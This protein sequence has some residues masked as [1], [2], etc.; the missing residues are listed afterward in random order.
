MKF[1]IPRD[2]LEQGLFTA[3]QHKLFVEVL[4]GTRK[5]TRLNPE[6][7]E[8]YQKEF[9]DNRAEQCDSWFMDTVLNMIEDHCQDVGVV[10]CMFA[11]TFDRDQ[12]PKFVRDVQEAVFNHMEKEKLYERRFL[13]SFF[14]IGG[15]W[16]WYVI[17]HY[18]KVCYT[19]DSFNQLAGLEKA[20]EEIHP[21][22]LLA[23][24]LR[25][26]RDAWK[27]LT[28][29][30]IAAFITRAVTCPEQLAYDSVSCGQLACASMITFLMRIH[31]DAQAIHRFA[32]PITGFDGRTAYFIKQRLV[33]SMAY[34][35]FK[36][37]LRSVSFEPAT[38]VEVTPQ[39]VAQ[40]S[41]TICLKMQVQET[42]DPVS[43][44]SMALERFCMENADVY[45]VPKPAPASIP[46]FLDPKS[47]LLSIC[48][49]Y[50]NKKSDTIRTKVFVG[51]QLN[52]VWIFRSYEELLVASV[53]VH[54]NVNKKGCDKSTVQ[55][56]QALTQNV[57][58]YTALVWNQQYNAIM[59]ATVWRT[60]LQSTQYNKDR[61]KVPKAKRVLI[62]S[63]GIWKV[64]QYGF[65]TYIKSR[66]PMEPG[67][68][69]FIEVQN[70]KGRKSKSNSKKIQTKMEQRRLTASP[71]GRPIRSKTWITIVKE[72]LSMTHC[73]QTAKAIFAYVKE[74]QPCY[75]P[76]LSKIRQA[77]T[78]GEQ[79]AAKRAAEF[80]N[81]EVVQGKTNQSFGGL[82]EN[83]RYH[84]ILPTNETKDE[85][86]EKCIVW[87]NFIPESDIT[88]CLMITI[89]NHLRVFSVDTTSSRLYTRYRI[90]CG[91]LIEF[92]SSGDGT[93][94]PNSRLLYM[95]KSH[96]AGQ[97]NV[98][99]YMHFGFTVFRAT[100]DIEI[101][102]FITQTEYNF[103]TF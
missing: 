1:G 40:N 9:H 17:D 83:Y 49:G 14:N 76:K 93:I 97:I 56:I 69:I 12:P 62:K 71:Y 87:M 77:L 64:T 86:G 89:P 7:A 74:T 96:D 102:E 78:S 23:S 39:P 3:E 50:F 65:D 88:G 72:V 99:T 57:I 101:G 61:T 28:K 5:S 22:P 16:Y 29:Q 59:D 51:C 43:E 20:Q 18:E 53:A 2:Y 35:N 100:R 45:V 8:S 103:M 95:T 52:P 24:L 58:A 75:E 46:R 41:N 36:Q 80:F 82:R 94:S 60:E 42:A 13:A 73:P 70:C 81:V 27:V 79:P 33:M 38:P 67:P 85:N 6:R 68:C 26:Y 10:S 4:N 98:E 54:S 30:N 11:H 92:E 48:P 55:P 63:N 34:A 32:E 91:T 44:F 66:D 84:K 25:S 31:H 37:T 21:Q 47:T 19:G 15:H 90:L